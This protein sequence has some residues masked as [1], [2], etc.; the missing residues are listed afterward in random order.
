MVTTTR[1]SVGLNGLSQS[2]WS[3]Q[4]NVI[5]CRELRSI[6]SALSFASVVHSRSFEKENKNENGIENKIEDQTSFKMRS[7]PQ[8]EDI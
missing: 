4:I 5:Q 6:L 3:S 1:F 2:N 8:T 7:R